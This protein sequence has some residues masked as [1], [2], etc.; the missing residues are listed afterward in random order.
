[1]QLSMID[2][3]DS[4]L[5]DGGLGPTQR[6]C[7]ACWFQRQLCMDRRRK[8]VNLIAADRMLVSTLK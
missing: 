4:G 3:G 6:P 5:P 1:M 8:S 7:R 2:Q